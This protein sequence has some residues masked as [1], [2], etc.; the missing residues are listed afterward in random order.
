MSTFHEAQHAGPQATCREREAA[1]PFPPVLLAK[2]E[3]IA[4]VHKAAGKGHSSAL[5]SHPC[6][7]RSVMLCV[8]VTALTVHRLE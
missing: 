4:N 6:C 7:H 3:R 5:T 8:P 1:A 2:T